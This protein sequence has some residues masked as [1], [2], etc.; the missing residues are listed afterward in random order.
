MLGFLG[1][2][3]RPSA[4]ART[5]ASATA[6]MT[7]AAAGGGVSGISLRVPL[8]DPLCSWCGKSYVSSRAQHACHGGMVSADCFVEVG[9]CKAPK[10]GPCGIQEA[11]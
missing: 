7:V 2:A 3:G 6:T 9:Q 5:T 10:G 4:R 11:R 8:E 1:G